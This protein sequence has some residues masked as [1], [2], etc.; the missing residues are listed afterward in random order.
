MSILKEDT[1][2]LD[3]SAAIEQALE[4]QG[5]DIQALLERRR[6]TRWAP[7][8]IHTAAGTPPGWVSAALSMHLATALG[9]QGGHTGCLESQAK[10]IHTGAG[11]RRTIWRVTAPTTPRS[12]SADSRRTLSRCVKACLHA[13]SAK[14]CT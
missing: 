9:P 6:F 8:L 4:Q 10:V 7:S 11:R 2:A 14:S 1:N 3:N 12:R 5:R 13:N